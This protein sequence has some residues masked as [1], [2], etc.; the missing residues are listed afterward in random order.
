MKM[1]LL[2]EQCKGHIKS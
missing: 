2:H 1:Q